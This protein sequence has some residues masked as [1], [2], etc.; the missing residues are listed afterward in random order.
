MEGEG[1]DIPEPSSLNTMLALEQSGE[2]K[3]GFWMMLD[4]DVDRLDTPKERVNLAIPKNA[5][6][7][8]DRYAA[9]HNMKRSGFMVAAA[10]KVARGG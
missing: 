1:L 7:E 10:L 3:G 8:I 6:R 9:R 5:L 2:Y 4:I